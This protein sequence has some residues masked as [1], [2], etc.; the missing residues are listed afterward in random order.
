M[1][2]YS[3]E[4]VISTFFCSIIVATENRL[5]RRPNRAC[6]PMLKPSTIMFVVGTISIRRESLC[7]AVHWAV[8]SPYIWVERTIDGCSC[9]FSCSFFIASDLAQTDASPPLHC[10]MLENTFTSIPEM[11][12]R[13]FQVFLLDYIPHWCYKNLVGRTC[14]DTLRTSL[15]LSCSY[16]PSPKFVTFKCPFSF[17]PASKMNW[18]HCR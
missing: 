13:L 14:G 3:T 2:T 5:V 11:A 1:L 6:T 18:F 12:K 16:C 8:L 9:S 7:L 15:F 10:V 17:S 4:R